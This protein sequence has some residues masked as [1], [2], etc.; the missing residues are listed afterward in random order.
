MSLVYRAAGLSHR[1]AAAQPV[2]PGDNITSGVR[3]PAP[4][5]IS[6]QRRPQG[7]CCACQQRPAVFFHELKIRNGRGNQSWGL[8]LC[9]ACYAAVAPLDPVAELLWFQQ[10]GV[11]AMAMAS[12][13]AAL[14]LAPAGNQRRIKVCRPRRPAPYGSRGERENG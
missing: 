8:H 4:L 9:E 5:A 10:M 3:V 13:K 14:A 1:A 12:V 7:C 2:G 6:P 11:D